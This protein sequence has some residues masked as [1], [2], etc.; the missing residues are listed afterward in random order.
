MFNSSLKQSVRTRTPISITSE[1]ET[2][3]YATWVELCTIHCRSHD[4]IHHIIPLAPGEIGD[5]DSNLWLKLD[6]IFLAWIYSTIS[7][8]LLHTI[9]I[10]DSTA[11]QTWNRLRDIFQDNG[12]SKE[13]STINM[14]NF[15]NVTSYCQQLKS[16]AAQ[17]QNVGAPILVQ[18]VAGLI[19]AYNNIGTLINHMNQI[20]L[21]HR[22][23]PLI[24]SRRCTL[25]ALIQKIQV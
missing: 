9:M 21:N 7:I 4:V 1:I 2:T 22:L 25:L 8:D 5:E 13:F 24:L 3:H 17:L 16:L 10:P 18:M 15:P 12:N 11:E 6:A 19:D 23:I 20:V 14:A